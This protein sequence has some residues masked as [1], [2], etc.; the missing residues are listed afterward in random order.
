M[1]I[2][3]VVVT[4]TGVADASKLARGNGCASA[5]VLRRAGSDGQQLG[6]RLDS[7]GMGLL[8]ILVVW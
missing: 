4:C 3:A 8:I 6:S 2:P 1:E 5:H 7:V